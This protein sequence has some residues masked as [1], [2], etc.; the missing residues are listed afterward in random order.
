MTD[1]RAPDFSLECDPYER[2]DSRGRL[3]DATLS[4]HVE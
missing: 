4:T 2:I 1:W 3:R